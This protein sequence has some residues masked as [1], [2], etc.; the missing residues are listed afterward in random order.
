[1]WKTALYIKKWLHWRNLEDYCL[2]WFNNRTVNVLSLQYLALNKS[3]TK[4]EN[5]T[6]VCTVLVFPFSLV[7]Y[8]PDMSQNRGGYFSC[9]LKF[10][11]RSPPRACPESLPPLLCGL[12]TTPSSSHL[13]KCWKFSKIQ[14]RSVVL[15]KPP[16]TK[17]RLES[18]TAL[19]SGLRW[20]TAVYG[21]LLLTSQ[22][23]R[24]CF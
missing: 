5:W 23:E 12:S 19:G 10:Y 17:H 18:R 15:R 3:L 8:Q 16:T 2:A 11:T 4:L 24:V 6:N 7:Y 9:L 14:P 22:S 20:L 13:T 1:M 21:W